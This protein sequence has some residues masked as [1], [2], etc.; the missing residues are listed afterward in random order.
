MDKSNI[1]RSSEFYM[2][3]GDVLHMII[4]DEDGV[5]VDIELIGGGSVE[6][7]LKDYDGN[8]YDTVVI[9]NQEWIVQNLRTTHYGNGAN[10]PNLTADG[11]WIGT[12]AITTINYGY[13]YNWYA[14]TDVRNIAPIGWHVPSDAE[15]TTLR[16]TVGVNPGYVLREV[17]TTHWSTSGGLVINS[18]GFTGVGSGYRLSG[19]TG[20][21]T[22]SIFLTSEDVDATKSVAWWLYNE[23]QFEIPG[24]D[25]LKRYGGAIRLIKDDSTDPGTVTGNDGWIYSTVKIG[26][27]VWIAENLAE[28]QYR[29]GDPIVV[30][31]DNTAWN[32]LIT[33]ARCSYNN[34]EDNA[35]I[36]TPAV[37]SDGYCWYDNDIA[38]EDL[39]GA[40]YNWY[41]VDNANGLAYFERD[42]VQETGWRIPTDED[43]S[44]LAMAVGGL[45]IGGAVVKEAGTD[46]WSAPNSGATDSV[47]FKAMPGGY[48]DSTGTFSALTETGI[49]WSS[50]DYS[51]TPPSGQYYYMVH[52][53]IYFG[54][55]NNLKSF[56]LSVRCMRDVSGTPP[57]I[58]IDD[59]MKYLQTIN[60]NA[61]VVTTIVTTVATEPY[62]VFLLDSS[63]NDITSTVTISLAFVGAV[64]EV[65]IYSVDAL[66]NVKLKI[67][68]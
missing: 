11:D 12:S 31:T 65:Y 21:K 53:D 30:V 13:L 55:A 3:E 27:Q 38:N 41:A 22:Y 68:Y 32:A 39:Y 47:G 18:S 67:I 42:G 9:G 17:G 40:L 23:Y 36:I 25:W 45:A 63:G 8:E 50:L 48:R 43:W 5:P 49:H 66:S 37:Y 64:Y 44:D 20:L 35:L 1:F 57:P 7:V 62:N 24:G 46:H 51:D 52:D 4:I 59:E 14:A 60:L 2:G 29:N 28:T 54:F 34:N 33:G 26:S 15:F 58:I 16:A 10:I 6:S 56:G 61:G 19:F